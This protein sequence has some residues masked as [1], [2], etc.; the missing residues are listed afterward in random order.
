MSNGRA[1]TP[2][3]TG[4]LKRMAAAGYSDAEIAQHLQRDRDVIGA[5]RRAMN[6]QPGMAPALTA[7]M[8]RI[9]SRRFRLQFQ[10]RSYA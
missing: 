6:I 5:K 2:D 7:A 9:N 3:D 10:S 4:T 1:W 8:A